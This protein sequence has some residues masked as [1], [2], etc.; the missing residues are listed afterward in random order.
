[1]NVIVLFVSLFIVVKSSP[2]K[3]IFN[4]KPKV[5]SFG[6]DNVGSGVGKISIGVGLTTGVP[7]V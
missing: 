3:L 2:S 4:N 5:I 7:P 1:M 6:F